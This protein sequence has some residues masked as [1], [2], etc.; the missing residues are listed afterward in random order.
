MNATEWQNGAAALKTKITEAG[1]ALPFRA[2]RPKTSLAAM[3]PSVA[4]ATDAPRRYLT[5]P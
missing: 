3:P 4:Y 2:C 1:K 5:R